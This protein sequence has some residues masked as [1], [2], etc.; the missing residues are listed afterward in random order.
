MMDEQLPV[1][2]RVTLTRLI[3]AGEGGGRSEIH[4]APEGST[5]LRDS[6][7]E[8]TADFHRIICDRPTYDATVA[9]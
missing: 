1:L 8:N 9:V 4:I 2:S 5:R 3:R 7:F 6:P